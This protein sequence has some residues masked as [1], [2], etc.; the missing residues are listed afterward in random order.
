MR[1]NYKFYLF[2]QVTNQLVHALQQYVNASIIH[3]E[4]DKLWQVVEL[5]VKSLDACQS[6]I[7]Y[8]KT[9]SKKKQVS[10]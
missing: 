2:N 8:T 10:E 5:E 3:G 7:A 9:K 1:N 6:S 4:A